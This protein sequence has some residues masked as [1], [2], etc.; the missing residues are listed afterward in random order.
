[1]KQSDSPKKR[2]RAHNK[3]NPHPRLFL[4]A[5]SSLAHDD[6]IHTRELPHSVL[7]ERRRI[8]E[9]KL[10]RAQVYIRAVLFFPASAHNTR[11]ASV[12]PAHLARARA[13]FARVGVYYDSCDVRA[14]DRACR[15]LFH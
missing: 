8:K 1:M 2:H 3:F 11:V 9:K 14:A 6:I 5:V 7:I 13:G 4:R 12:I 10:Q 15:E